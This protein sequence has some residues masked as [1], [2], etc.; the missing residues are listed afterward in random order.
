MFGAVFAED[1]VTVLRGI[2][3]NVFIDR[4]IRVRPRSNG[5]VFPRALGA[6]VNH[7]AH[8]LTFWG[9]GCAKI[10]A[11]S[12]S[13]SVMKISFPG[14]STPKKYAENTVKIGFHRLAL[15]PRQALDAASQAKPLGSK[16]APELPRSGALDQRIGV[17]LRPLT[18]LSVD[19]RVTA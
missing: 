16:S 18:T 4:R 17:I 1:V 2:P 11:K 15:E 10:H 12:C 7:C 14:L 9:A 19:V 8:L 5:D 13:V 6:P 3:K